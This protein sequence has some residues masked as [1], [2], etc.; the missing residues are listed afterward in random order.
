MANGANTASAMTSCSIL[1]WASDMPE[2]YPMRLAGTWIRYSN[3]AIPQL[4]SAATY[5]GLACRCFRCP[6]QAN[7]MKRLD[8][9]SNVAVTARVCRGVINQTR[10]G[11]DDE[12]Y[13]VKWP[14]PPRLPAA[15]GSL[16][17]SPPHDFP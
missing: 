10:R 15:S 1:S 6:Y 3:S 17:G 14:A 12:F 16:H 9:A 7:V 8:A 11:K 13:R 4:T 5:H 2:P